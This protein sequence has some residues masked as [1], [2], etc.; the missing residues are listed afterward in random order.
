MSARTTAHAQTTGAGTEQWEPTIH[1]V[2]Q[3]RRLL[4]ESLALLRQTDDRWAR[5]WA[6]AFF[7]DALMDETTGESSPH[8]RRDSVAARAVYEES[9]AIRREL[10]DQQ[11]AANALAGLAQVRF[12]KSG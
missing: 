7:G 10:G 1:D 5:A 9:L 3:A 11:G 8:L 2:L 12:G 4:A 6:L